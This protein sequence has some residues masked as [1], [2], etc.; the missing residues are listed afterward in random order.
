M[1]V[2][3]VRVEA[4]MLPERVRRRCRSPSWPLVPGGIWKCSKIPSPLRHCAAS[5]CAQPGKLA[6]EIKPWCVWIF[7]LRAVRFGAQHISATFHLADLNLWEN[8]CFS[9][10]NKKYTI[11]F[12]SYCFLFSRV[13][14]LFEIK[15]ICM[16]EK[17]C[18]CDCFI[19]E[20]WTWVDFILKH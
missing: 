16:N 18:V 17:M 9:L 5:A 13:A 6:S 3:V 2:A 15:K 20:A 19:F 7:T 12:Y 11:P 14:V 8:V 1:L 4:A 10:I